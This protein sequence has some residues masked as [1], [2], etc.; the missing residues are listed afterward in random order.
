MWIRSTLVQV[1]VNVPDIPNR[2]RACVGSFMVAPCVEE[3]NRTLVVYI[4]ATDTYK[5]TGHSRP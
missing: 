2:I 4:Y 1:V 5:F 3:P